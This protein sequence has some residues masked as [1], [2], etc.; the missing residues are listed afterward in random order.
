MK[1]LYSTVLMLTMIVAALS[2]IACGGDDD[3]IDNGGGEASIV[4]MWECTYFDFDSDLP[5]MN[6]DSILILTLPHQT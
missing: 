2:F 4:G 5:G 6:A 1:K 3:E